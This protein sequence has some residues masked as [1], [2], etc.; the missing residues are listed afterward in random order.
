[1]RPKTV[2]GS[3]ALILCAPL[4]QAKQS[5]AQEPT[6]YCNRY[7]SFVTFHKDSVF[8]EFG[9][10]FPTS[11]GKR[12]LSMNVARSVLNTR[13]CATASLFCIEELPSN[14]MT[15]ASSL[16]YALPKVIAVGNEYSVAGA[17]FSVRDFPPLPGRPRAVVVAA[18]PIGDSPRHRFKMY[19][20]QG[21]G[22]RSLYFE[23]LYS[24]EPAGLEYE[25]V[26]CSLVSERGLFSDVV[27]TA[28]EPSK[29]PKHVD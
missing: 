28:V 29:E 15:L 6:Y 2:A 9:V 13:S 4:A 23:R 26:T 3:V 16:V 14:Q 11:K 27:I 1:M 20:E 5:A 24:T 10:E 17:K 7:E 21:I 22:V 12:S 8:K 18:M 25:H 19:V